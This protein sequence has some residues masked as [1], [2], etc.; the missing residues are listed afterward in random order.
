M[1]WKLRI[2][3]SRNLPRTPVRRLVRLFGLDRAKQ[4]PA[5]P[6]GSAIEVSL[7]C[8][9]SLPSTNLPCSIPYYKPSQADV[10]AWFPA[11][12]VEYWNSCLPR[13]FALG[14]AQWVHRG[15]FSRDRI[16]PSK[17]NSNSNTWNMITST[18]LVTG[19]Q[20]SLC[21]KN[22]K[23]ELYIGGLF[24]VRVLHIIGEERSSNTTIR[25]SCRETNRLIPLP[26]Y[27]VTSSESHGVHETEKK[28]AAAKPPPCPDYIL[29]GGKKNAVYMM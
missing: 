1:T 20:G 18:S 11:E 23:T 3:C 5:L 12:F 28:K 9:W 29:N 15:Y 7:K 2:F 24:A 17:L 6:E 14:P 25:N 22:R 16:T 21:R 4:K 8:L 10:I 27:Q 26:T 13:Q 19:N